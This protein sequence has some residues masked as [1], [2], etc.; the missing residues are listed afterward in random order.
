MSTPLRPPA[1]RE[2]GKLGLALLMWLLGVPGGIVLLYLIL[3]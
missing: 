3:G 2:S 1:N